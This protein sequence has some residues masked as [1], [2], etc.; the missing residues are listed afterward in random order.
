MIGEFN[1]Y[2][3]AKTAAL[4][5]GGHVVRC[6]DVS[7]F[8]YIWPAENGPCRKCGAPHVR[9]VLKSEVYLCNPCFVIKGKAEV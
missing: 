8:G 2:E 1:A 9:R 4:S 6:N 5:A 3:D 7:K